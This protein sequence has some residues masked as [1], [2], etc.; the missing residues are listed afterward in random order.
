[1]SPDA[2]QI[3][4]KSYVVL[5]GSTLVAFGKTLLPLPLPLPLPDTVQWQETISSSSR[6]PFDARRPQLFATQL[7]LRYLPPFF[8]RDTLLSEK[9]LPCRIRYIMIISPPSSFFLALRAA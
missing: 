5:V 1:M 3:S 6:F 8:V 9:V 4:P 7:T 2:L